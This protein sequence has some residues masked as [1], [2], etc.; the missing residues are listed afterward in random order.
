MVLCAGCR[1]GVCC[2]TRHGEKGCLESSP[3][4]QSPYLI[5]YCRFCVSAGESSDFDVS[6]TPFQTVTSV[7]TS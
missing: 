5:Y 1:V 4:L 6:L 7:H 2:G 3:A